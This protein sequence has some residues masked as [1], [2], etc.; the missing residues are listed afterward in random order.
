MSV[1]SAMSLKFIGVALCVLL[2]RLLAQCAVL[3]FVVVALCFLC[4]CE[5]VGKVVVVVVE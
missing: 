2:C 3:M 5:V 1:L 4:F